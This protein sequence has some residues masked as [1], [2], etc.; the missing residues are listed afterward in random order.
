M[1]LDLNQFGKNYILFTRY[2]FNVIIVVGIAFITLLF[3]ADEETTGIVF[4][5]LQVFSGLTLLFLP[6]GIVLAVIAKTR[7]LGGAFLYFIA[8][9]SLAYW[10][11]AGLIILQQKG[12]TAW[13]IVGIVVSFFT[14]GFGLF[15][16]TV[17]NAILHHAWTGV[18]MF[19]GI[20]LVCKAVMNFSKALMEITPQQIEQKVKDFEETQ[21]LE[22]KKIDE[23]IQVLEIEQN[24]KRE[25]IA[26]LDEELN[27]FDN[28]DDYFEDDEYDDLSEDEIKLKI[29]ESELEIEQLEKEIEQKQ[30]DAQG[31]LIKMMYESPA[32]EEFVYGL[33]EERELEEGTAERYSRDALLTWKKGNG[34]NAL[35]LYNKALKINPDSAVDLINRGNLLIEL[36]KFDE[37]IADLE[38]ASKI[39]STLPTHLATMLKIMS[40]EV[41]EGFRQRMLEKKKNDS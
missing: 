19:I 27:E 16:V 26:L 24:E 9:V 32:V 4:L 34:E 40:P 6:V 41:R 20:P 39:D 1:E 5:A 8:T 29:K 28:Y 22:L 33:A 13:A 25:Q 37:G 14:S 11:I 36:G 10:W 18:F 30:K 2:L 15:F 7:K 21:E 12:G 35:L 17:I 23:K 3:L 31:E 38:K